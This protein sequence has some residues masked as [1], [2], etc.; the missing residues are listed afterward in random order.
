MSYIRAHKVK[1]SSTTAITDV[2]HV[3]N[4]YLDYNLDDEELKFVRDLLARIDN[5]GEG[6]AL[7]VW[8]E[9]F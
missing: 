9:I 5:L 3:A 2:V 7:V 4:P 1:Q 8:K 6:E